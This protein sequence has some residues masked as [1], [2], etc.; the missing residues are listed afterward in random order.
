MRVRAI[1]TY[2]VYRLYDMH[3]DEMTIVRDVHSLQEMFKD[4]SHSHIE[5]L[6]RENGLLTALDRL[7]GKTEKVTDCLRTANLQR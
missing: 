2:R 7:L 1:P 5:Q 4:A 3:M 6:V